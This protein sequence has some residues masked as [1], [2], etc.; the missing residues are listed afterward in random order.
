MLSIEASG[1]LTIVGLAGV[2]VD[3]ALCGW[4]LA[5]HTA[6]LKRGQKHGRYY[7]FCRLH[8]YRRFR[9]IETPATM[10]IK[11]IASKSV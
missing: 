2:D 4:R 7:K 8:R 10:T 9:K 1:I 5:H 3:V 6:P 11:G